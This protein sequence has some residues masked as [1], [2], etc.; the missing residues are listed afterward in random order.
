M[1]KKNRWAFWLV[2]YV[3]DLN[4]KNLLSFHTHYYPFLII[5]I[6]HVIQFGYTHSVQASVANGTQ[7][8]HEQRLNLTSL[9]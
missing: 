2:G 7:G 9:T 6:E 1:I 8:L 5:I 4:A 3:K